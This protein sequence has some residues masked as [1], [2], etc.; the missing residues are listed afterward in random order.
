MRSVIIV[1]NEKKS[2][3]LNPVLDGVEGVFVCSMFDWFNY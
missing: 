2:L 3:Q 1:L